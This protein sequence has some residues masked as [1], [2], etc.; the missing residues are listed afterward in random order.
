MHPD[1]R[2]CLS[3][4]R[5]SCTVGCGLWVPSGCMPAELWLVGCRVA[6]SLGLGSARAVWLAL[7]LARSSLAVLR[8]CHVSGPG[9]SLQGACEA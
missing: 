9:S 5:L 6:A 3:V 4:S 7:M 8:T 1:Q 2:I